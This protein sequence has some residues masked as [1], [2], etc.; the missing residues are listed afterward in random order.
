[1]KNLISLV[2]KS[3]IF[4]LFVIFVSSIILSACGIGVAESEITVYKDKYKLVTVIKISSDQIQMIGGPQVFEDEMDDYVLEAQKEGIKIDWRDVSKDKSSTYSYEISTGFIETLDPD[5]RDFS[6]EET[7]FDDRK[8][9]EFRYS[10]YAS[11]LSAFQSHTLTLH[12]GKILDSNGT[13]LDSGTVTWV[14]ASVSPYA[15]VIPKGS[16]SWLW[17]ILAIALLIAAGFV[18]YKLVKSKKLSD[19]GSTVFNVSKW[20]IQETKLTGE[21]KTLEQ[22]KNNLIKDLGA[23]AWESRIFDSTYSDLYEKLQNYDQQL[24][25][26]KVEKKTLDTSLQDVQRTYTE[27]DSHYSKQ[28]TQLQT[29]LKNVNANL[30]KYREDQSNLDKEAAKL[31]KEKSRLSSEIQNYEKKLTAIQSS[32]AEDK[33]NQGLS[34]TSAMSTL[35]KT[36]E[37]IFNQIPAVQ[38]RLEALKT[39]QAPLLEKAESLKVQISEAQAEQKS[40][41]QPLS[42]QI[43]DLDTQIAQK[44]V[45]ISDLEKQ[46]DPLISS[47]GP[48]V[49]SARPESATLRPVYENLDKKNSELQAKNEENSLIKAR[50]GLRDKNAI[51]NFLLTMLGLIII[52]VLV[53]ILLSAAL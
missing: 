43:K 5:M 4:V 33:D 36:L 25:G 24:S 42:L 21:I 18:V 32:G 29:D 46:M 45:S 47:L 3:H 8:A 35:N 53:V 10:P 26:L 52:V 7:T 50:L 22:E 14:N 38:T 13:Q 1:M 12:A 27:I 40:K 16:N 15:I 51:R 23:K 6:W 9:Y 20:K 34:L 41:L 44:K 19:W 2:R 39:E 31:D 48:L 28:L 17:L 37:D 11:L 49:D 30:T